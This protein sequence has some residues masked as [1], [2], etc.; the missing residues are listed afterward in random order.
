MAGW[1][2]A[3]KPDMAALSHEAQQKI[4]RRCRTRK[5]VRVIYHLHSPPSLPL[6]HSRR[7][8]SLIVTGSSSTTLR[9]RPRTGGI[10]GTSRRLARRAC[11]EFGD[12]ARRDMA[13]A[14]RRRLVVDEQLL[15]IDPDRGRERS[16]RQGF[17]DDRLNGARSPFRQPV[18]H[19]ARPGAPRGSGEAATRMAPVRPGGRASKDERGRSD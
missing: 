12:G 19:L 11:P 9:G 18:A 17:I 5:G 7:F 1:F 14:R 3:L 4:F 13:R 2:S 15:T 8:S 10:R 16:I 6:D